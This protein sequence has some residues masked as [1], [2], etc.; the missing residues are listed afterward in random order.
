MKLGKPV[1]ALVVASGLFAACNMAVH[2]PLDVRPATQFV[3]PGHAITGRVVNPDGKITVALQNYVTHERSTCSYDSDKKKFSCPTSTDAE[4]L[5]VVGVTDVGQ[6]KEGTK[7]ARV[8]VTTLD[9]YAPKVSVQEKAKAGKDVTVSL[10][11][12][13]ADRTVTVTVLDTKRETV[14]TGMTKTAND[15]GGQVNVK[16]LKPGG[17]SL[18]VAD[19]LW[20]VGGPGSGTRLVLTVS[21]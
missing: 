5:Y 12:W 7:K 13:G 9:G 4:G 18:E 11:M 16:G 15:G 20:N 10:L 8:A 2:S 21:K 6:P 3:Q 1:T 19:R 14:F 17:Y